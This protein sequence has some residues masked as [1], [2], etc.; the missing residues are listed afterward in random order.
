MLEYPQTLET[1][2]DYEFIRKNFPKN[3]WDHDYLELLMD[4]YTNVVVGK[5]PTWYF[6]DEK[7]PESAEFSCTP[8]DKELEDTILS[9]EDKFTSEEK[10]NFFNRVVTYQGVKYLIR[11]EENQNSKLFQLGYTPDLIMAYLFELEI[12]EILLKQEE[13]A[14]E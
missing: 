3:I 6:K 11:L 1:R 8:I 10:V 9:N 14:D 2:E 5:S 13:K 12:P 7:D 4:A